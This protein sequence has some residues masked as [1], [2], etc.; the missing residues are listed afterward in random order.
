MADPAGIIGIGHN[1][2]P[3]SAATG[4][5]CSFILPEAYETLN[6]IKAMHFAEYRRYRM[7]MARLIDE[8]GAR[9]PERPFA[10]ALLS[11]VRCSTKL[12]DVDNLYGGIKPI[13]DCLVTRQ[14]A[15]HPNGKGFII[16]D[17]PLRLVLDIR[18]RLM[19]KR[20]EAKTLVELVELDGSHPDMVR[21]LVSMGLSE[22][23]AHEIATAPPPQDRTQSTEPAVRKRRESRRLLVQERMTANEYLVMAAAQAGRK[24]GRKRW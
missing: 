14:G 6:A 17:S 3:V 11:I 18:P 7:R 5:T 22:A 2:P 21:R 13:V 15:R 1:G 12:L 9:P 19:A 23:A 4:R 24:G 20:I 8:T 16:D 10:F